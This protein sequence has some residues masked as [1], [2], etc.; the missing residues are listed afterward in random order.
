V[1]RRGRPPAQGALC[2]GE[3]LV[4]QQTAWHQGRV[5][6]R[7]E[8]ALQVSRDDDELEALAWKREAGEIGA[9]DLE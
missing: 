6:R 5:E 9:P 3:R 2:L 8:I 4:Q 1:V 7:E